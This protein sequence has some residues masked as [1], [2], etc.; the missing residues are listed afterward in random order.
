MPP[1]R[2]YRPPST[3]GGMTLSFP[4]FT[5]GVMWLLAINLGG[6][7]L[8]RLFSLSQPTMWIVDGVIK[9]FALQP[10]AALHGAVWQV[11]TYAFIHFDTLNII[12]VLLGIWFIGSFLESAWGTQRFLIFYLACAAGGGVGSMALAYALGVASDAHLIFAGANGAI[13]GMLVAIGVLWADLEFMMIPFPFMIKAKYMVAVAIVVDLVYSFREG[14]LVYL[15]E[16]GG[17]IYALFYVKLMM[18]NPRR[19]YAPGV[20]PGRGL[21][22][23]IYEPQPVKKP[24]LLARWRDSY[25]RWKRRRA[26]RKFE[27]YMRKHD[28]QVYFDEHGNYIDPE[29]AEGRR[30]EEDESKKP[31]IN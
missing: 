8:L 5:K 30:R 31:W 6:F 13:L 3:T 16:F 12:F 10:H 18:R 27:V 7:L 29:S 23:R 26:A 20:Y 1:K 4:P 17:L 19:Q 11:V 14:G 9:M 2:Q 28:R 21:S 15:G 22:D 25:Y 24:S